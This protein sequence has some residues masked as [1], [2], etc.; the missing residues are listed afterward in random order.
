MTQSAGTRVVVTGIGM[1]TPLGF[2]LEDQWTRSVRG[3]SAIG[4]ITRFDVDGFSCRS[5]GEVPEFE[6][7]RYLSNPKSQK[8]LGKNTSMAVRAAREAVAHAGV[9]LKSFDA[10]QV[11]VYTGSGETG[12]EGSEFFRAM[13]AAWDGSDEMDFKDL[14]GRSSRLIPPYFSLRT[15]SNAGVAFL[16][17]ELGARGTSN[18]FIHGDTASAQA[19][20]NALYDLAENRCQIAIA[21][22]YDSLLNPSTY[23][24]YH[25]IGLLSGGEP[26]CSYRPFDARRDGLVLGE[27]AAFLVLETVENAERRGARV[28]AEVVQIEFFTDPSDSLEPKSNVENFCSRV[29]A[30]LAGVVPD[31]VIAH[32]IGTREG[33]L[34]EA[35]MLRALFG[36]DT[37]VTALKSHT[38][39]LGAAT[40]AVELAF[41][42]FALQDGDVPPIARHESTDPDVELDLVIGQPR[43]IAVAEP[44]ALCFTWSWG[45]QCNWTLL[46]KPSSQE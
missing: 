19:V 36:S 3:D 45:G 31:F 25:K 37:P 44:T 40:A 6:V 23:L 5:A 29:D 12:L 38:G 11:G 43:P 1:V 15:L 46:K 30:A 26:A 24:A 16:A 17:T 35:K 10:Y 18:N 33:D 14:G 42:T 9:D 21:G 2:T 13:S 41:A 22:G 34:A 27:G 4:A 32:G 20:S 8:F 39:Y 7:A 28:L